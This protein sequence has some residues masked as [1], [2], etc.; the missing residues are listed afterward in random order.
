MP[1]E[2]LKNRSVRRKTTLDR[3]KRPVRSAS[4]RASLGASAPFQS[5]PEDFLTPVT[6]TTLAADICRKMVGHL[7]RG[8]WQ[9]GERIPAERELSQRLNVGRSSL[10]EALKALEIMGMI[11][12]R[13]GEGTYVCKRS[14]FLSAPLLWAITSSSAPDAHELVEARVLIET[15]LAGLAAERS[16]PANLKTMAEQIVLMENSIDDPMPFANADVEFH[17]AIGEAAKN[18]ILVNALRLIRNLLHQWVLQSLAAP[19]IPRKASHQHKQI[20]AAIAARKR[21]AARKAMRTHLNEM[22]KPLLRAQRAQPMDM[23]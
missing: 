19:G 16:T 12:T 7:I 4:V 10:R 20:F 5:F 11:E 22:A 21:D 13:L 23:R 15:E 9:A 8:D 18:N 3:S 14:R 2:T 1:K 6:R 17:I